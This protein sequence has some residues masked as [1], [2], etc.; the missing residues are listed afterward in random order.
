VDDGLAARL[1]DRAAVQRRPGSG[2]LAGLGRVGASVAGASA[3]VTRPAEGD[4][5]G[6]RDAST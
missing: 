1:D 4:G 5:L 2:A 6:L 3:M